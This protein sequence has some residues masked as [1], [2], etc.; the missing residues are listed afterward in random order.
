MTEAQVESQKET[1]HA[2]ESGHKPAAPP[3]AGCKLYSPAAL[4]TYTLISN[5]GIGLIL[6][7][8]NLRARGERRLSRVMLSFGVVALVLLMI[9]SMQ[10]APPSRSLLMVV[11]AAMY[12][13]RLEKVPFTTAMAQGASRARWWPPAVWFM[14][15]A[16]LLL[17][18]K[19]VMAGNL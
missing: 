15:M 3:M 17:G 5:P 8:V 11:V 10:A 6:Y 16:V 19:Y 12:L 13:Y 18:L 2:E 7:S 9:L 4:A 1:D 14:V